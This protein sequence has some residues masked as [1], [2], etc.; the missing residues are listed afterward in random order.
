MTRGPKPA[1]EK[2]ELL[3]LSLPPYLVARLKLF[4]WSDLE[5]RVPK[6]AYQK[7]FTD[8]LR[9]YFDLYKPLDVSSFLGVPP[10]THVVLGEASTIAA[11]LHHLKGNES[12]KSTL[13]KS[14]DPPFLEI[15]PHSA[16]ESD[17]SRTDQ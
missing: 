4:L 15:P 14:N 17:S 3:N 7:F 12:C 11:L 16:V 10:S 13:S 9:E 5:G 8:R 2:N 1:V 6:G